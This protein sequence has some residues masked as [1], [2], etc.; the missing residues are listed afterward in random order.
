MIYI[1]SKNGESDIDCEGT[2]VVVIADL[3]FGVRHMFAHIIDES[4][5]E[6]AFTMY[7]VMLNALNEGEPLSWESIVK[8]AHTKRGNDNEV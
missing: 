4:S 2:G 3:I 5:E 8:S 1:K 6:T 7:R